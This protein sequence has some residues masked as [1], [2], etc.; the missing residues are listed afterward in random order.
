VVDFWWTQYWT[1]VFYK[2]R[3]TFDYIIMYHLPT[4]ENLTISL[5]WVSINRKQNGP[6]YLWMWAGLFQATGVGICRSILCPGVHCS[7]G[8][9]KTWTEELVFTKQMYGCYISHEPSAEKLVRICTNNDRTIA[10]TLIQ[11]KTNIKFHTFIFITPSSC[12]AF[13]P[14]SYVHPIIIPL[15]LPSSPSFTLRRSEQI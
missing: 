11:Q 9:A 3:G 13:Q 1:L 14:V 12:M 5:L 15:P 4:E 8:L 7:S 10:G 2:S 6:M